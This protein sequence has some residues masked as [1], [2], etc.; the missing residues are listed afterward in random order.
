MV[1]HGYKEAGF[2]QPDGELRWVLLFRRWL[3]LIETAAMVRDQK[4]ALGIGA[5]TR[6]LHGGVGQLLMPDNLAVVVANTPDLAGGPIAVEIGAPQLRQLGPVID[7]AAGQRTHFGM[8]V[9]HRRQRDG[10]GAGLP[11]QVKR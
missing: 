6:D 1:L 9:L 8:G 3:Q 10:R 2:A 7:D 4:L 5:E 11:S